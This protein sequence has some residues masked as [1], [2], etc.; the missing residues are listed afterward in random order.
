M[1][2][3]VKGPEEEL[4]GN[5]RRLILAP[6]K[7]YRHHL[8]RHERSRPGAGFGMVRGGHWMFLGW[9]WGGIVVVLGSSL[10]AP[11]SGDLPCRPL[12]GQCSDPIA[13]LPHVGELI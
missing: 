13:T 10:R 11:P 5:F 3:L 12:V 4:R 8:F 1:D 6:L 2:L 7:S 9:L